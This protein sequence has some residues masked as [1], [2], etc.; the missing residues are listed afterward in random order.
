MLAPQRM[1]PRTLGALDEDAP[2]TR[3]VTPSIEVLGD[4][5]RDLV[6]H[7][8]KIHR[9][10]LREMHPHERCAVGRLRIAA[11][12]SYTRRAADTAD[13][14]EGVPDGDVPGGRSRGVELGDD[15]TWEDF[16]DREAHVLNV[17][18]AD[19]VGVSDLDDGLG[20]GVVGVVGEEGA[21]T[22]DGGPGFA[23]DAG[24]ERDEE[25]GFDAVFA[26]GEVG[27]FVVGGGVLEDC[28]E[29]GSIVED[30]VGLDSV[31][32]VLGGVFDVDEVRDGV[33][34]VVGRRE[35]GVAAAGR[36]VGGPGRVVADVSVD[37][38]L[39]DSVGAGE[40]GQV[41]LGGEDES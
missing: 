24:V 4:M 36:E 7:I 28:I 11:C 29:G 15:C 25:C 37:R 32:A 21:S 30:I 19:I 6:L 1:Q 17:D 38:V 14:D 8:L 41:G 16:R 18:C 12:I 33:G 20:V 26:E 10:R 31:A 5:V 22:G 40:A 3:D 27:D 39:A 13:G 9:R 2:A 35:I 23:D 34:G